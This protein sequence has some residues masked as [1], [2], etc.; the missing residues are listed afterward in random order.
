M[1]PAGIS[2]SATERDVPVVLD[3]R[4]SYASLG[5]VSSVYILTVEPRPSPPAK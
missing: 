5:P 2:S 1:N 3:S 4:L